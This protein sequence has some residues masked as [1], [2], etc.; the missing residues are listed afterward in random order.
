MPIH[1]AQSESSTVLT[2]LLGTDLKLENST[3]GSPC[4]VADIMESRNGTIVGWAVNATLTGSPVSC[5]GLTQ[6][7]WPIDQLLLPQSYYSSQNASALQSA[8]SV[9]PSP[10]LLA[11]SPPGSNGSQV[12]AAGTISPSSP[13]SSKA[14][15]RW[16]MG[17]IGAGTLASLVIALLIAS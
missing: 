6:F 16:S 11:G 15:V 8:Q 17:S 5:S 9:S 4:S 14:Q 7:L 1:R 2:N 10:S 13:P 12:L 3:T